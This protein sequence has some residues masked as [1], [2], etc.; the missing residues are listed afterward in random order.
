MH[1]RNFLCLFAALPLV[2]A[3]VPEAD[4]TIVLGP[5][6]MVDLKYG[7]DS[8]FFVAHQTATSCGPIMLDLGDRLVLLRDGSDPHSPKL[9][10]PGRA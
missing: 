6:M 5:G 9:L 3:P 1:R 10:R 2:K 4:E 8:S 7:D